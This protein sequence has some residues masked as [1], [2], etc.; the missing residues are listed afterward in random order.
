MVI[1]VFLC[2]FSHDIHRD[3]GGEALTDVFQEM[4]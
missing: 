2:L 1:Q 3:G 4:V